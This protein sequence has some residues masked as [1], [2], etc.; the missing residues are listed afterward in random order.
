MSAAATETSCFGDTS[1]RSTFS[2]GM[3]PRYRRPA[4]E[5]LRVTGVGDNAFI[6]REFSLAAP[7][8]L[9]IYALGEQTGEWSDYGWIQQ[10]GSSRRV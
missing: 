10:T 8:T 4:E 7:A 6:R 9:K 2:G 5:V 3:P 1:M